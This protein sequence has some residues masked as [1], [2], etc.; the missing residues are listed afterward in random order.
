MASYSSA[1]AFVTNFGQAL[2]Y[3]VK[4]SVD[5]MVWTPSTVQTNIS[6]NIA[7]GEKLEKGLKMGM[8]VES[9]VTQMLQRLGRASITVGSWRHEIDR[10]GLVNCYSAACCGRKIAKELNKAQKEETP[11]Q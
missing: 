6:A 10:W 5:V 4:D 2:H 1:K 8:E 3:E 7:S 9:A 11:A